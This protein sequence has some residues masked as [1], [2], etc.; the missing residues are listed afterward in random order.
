MR[1]AVKVAML[2]MSAG[3]PA[4]GDTLEDGVGE[5]LVH[6]FI[7]EITTLQGQFEQSLIDAKGQI[8]DVTSGTL[9]I[10]RPG[11]FRWTYIEP[12]E[13]VLVADG[14]NVWS[15]DVD[16]AQ[17]TVKPQSEAL[18]NTPALLL[19][20]AED[21]MEQ[22]VTEGSF[23][24]SGT[25]WV[26]LTPKNTESGFVRI[27]LGFADQQLS[28]MAFFDNLE[29]TTLVDLSN[30]I[31]NEPIDQGRFEFRVPDGVDVVGTPAVTDATAP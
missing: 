8:V 4:I 25:T 22:F 5:Q 6:D 7:T 11:R 15:Y 30:V 1:V 20:G 26:T 9:E 16:L 19:S 13:Q 17:V 23:V 14:L 28:R 18:S 2:A 10:Q 27:E 24:E 21:A 31:V 12:Y 3:H 29:Q